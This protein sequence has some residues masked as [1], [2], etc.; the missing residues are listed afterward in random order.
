MAKAL[1]SAIGI[2]LGQYNL[3]GVLLQRKGGNRVHI[4]G[5]AIRQTGPGAVPA[6]KLAH[7]LKLLLQEVGG[8]AKGYAAAASSPQALVR[9]ID[10]PPTPPVLLRDALKFNDMALLNQDCK[11]YVL[12]CDLLT[13]PSKSMAEADDAPAAATPAAGAP[14]KTLRYVVGGLPRSDVSDIYDAFEKNRTVISRLQLA[15]LATFNAFEF[16][17]RDIFTN[18]AF[19]LVDIGHDVTVVM[20]GCKRELVLVRNIDYGGRHFIEAISGDGAIDLA[21]AIT[22]VE[23][24]DPGLNEVGRASLMSLAVQLR[25]SIGFFEGQREENISRVHFS[26]AL[27]RADL[28]LQILSDE[29]EIPCE[30]W[31]PFEKCEISL[32]RNKRT[33]FL[34]DQHQLNVACGA[35]IELLSGGG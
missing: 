23:K 15:P 6:D 26:G 18:E 34:V 33:S 32:P 30:L 8:S 25:N 13:Q 10:Q 27:V 21:A 12:D 22:L 4:A 28:P 7:H 9:I 1:N 19:M 35:A 20:L 31:D 14:A 3:K 29:L 5:Y 24:G 17:K 2:D 16:A 11:E